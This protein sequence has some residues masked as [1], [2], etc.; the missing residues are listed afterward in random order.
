MS[1]NGKR[2]DCKWCQFAHECGSKVW[3]CD[4]CGS[5]RD[6][7]PQEVQSPSCDPTTPRTRKRWSGRRRHAAC[8][9]GRG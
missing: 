3:E 4:Q 9:D 1:G 5:L 6:L 7:R 8:C 2:F